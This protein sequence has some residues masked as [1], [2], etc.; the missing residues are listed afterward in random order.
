MFRKI[1]RPN[2]APPLPP[3]KDSYLPF[4]KIAVNHHSTMHFANMFCLLDSGCEASCVDEKLLKQL[5]AL[6]RM[7]ER[8][9]MGITTATGTTARVIGNIT[10][11]ITIGDKGT[12]K[13]TSFTHDF[14]VIES[15]ALNRILILGSNV[16]Q[17][18]AYVV[19][20]RPRSVDFRI[21][22]EYHVE[23]PKNFRAEVWYKDQMEKYELKV[24]F[25]THLDPGAGRWITMQAMNV[26]KDTD[27]LEITKVPTITDLTI[28]NIA[29]SPYKNLVTAY[30]ENTTNKPLIL[31][32]GETIANAKI[33]NKEII[34][35]YVMADADVKTVHRNISD[36]GEKPLSTKM[37][38]ITSIDNMPIDP[39]EMAETCLG[40]HFDMDN[41][42]PAI[43]PLRERFRV[44]DIPAEQ[45]KVLLDIAEKFPNVWA[46]SKLDIGTVP[47]LFVPLDVSDKVFCDKYRG[48]PK[49]TRHIIEAILQKYLDAG[50]LEIAP[51]SP[52]AMNLFLI[53]KPIPPHVL[54]ANPEAINSPE[55]YRTLLDAR[56]L[57]KNTQG[58]SLSLGQYE[59]LFLQLGSAK[60][61]IAIDIVS[62]YFNIRIKPEHRIYTSFYSTNPGEKLMF[63]RLGMGMTNSALEFVKLMTRIFKP[64]QQSV[65]MYMDDV[66]LFADSFEHICNTF[67]AALKILQENGLKLLPDKTELL[68][69]TIKFV[70]LQWDRNGTLSV[71]DAKIHA[72]SSWPVPL[73]TKKKIQSFCSAIQFFRRFIEDLSGKL[74][75]LTNMLKTGAKI[76]WNES[77]KMAFDQAI[78][79]LKQNVTLYIPPPNTSFI[80]H[81]DASKY[82]CAARLSYLDNDKIERLV[83]CASRTFSDTATRY[84]TYHQEL[85]ALIFAIRTYEGWCAFTPTTIYVDCISLTY[86]A[87]TKNSTASVMRISIYLSQFGNYKYVHVRSARNMADSLTRNEHQI[88]EV[89]ARNTIPPLTQIEAETLLQRL[90][91]PDGTEFSE[92]TVRLLLA[93]YPLPS[94]FSKKV[95]CRCKVVI[96]PTSKDIISTNPID[97]YFDN[98]EVNDNICADKK[99]LQNIDFKLIGVNNCNLIICDNDEKSA[100]RDTILALIANGQMSRTDLI[101]LQHADTYCDSICKQIIDNKTKTFY[102]DKGG[103]LRKRTECDNIENFSTDRIVLPEA[104]FKPLLY[105]SHSDSNYGAHIGSSHTLQTMRSKYFYPDMKHVIEEYCKSCLLCQIGKDDFQRRSIS[106]G[107]LRANRPRQIVAIDLSFSF[108]KTPKGHLGIAVMVDL[109]SNF[110]VAAPIR[111]KHSKELLEMFKFMYIIPFGIPESIRS[112]SE[113]GMMGGEFHDYCKQHEI[114]QYP[115]SSGSPWVNS[116]VEKKIHHLKDQ[117]RTIQAELKN[118]A[119]WVSLIPRI[120]GVNNNTVKTGK[121]TPY[122]IMFGSENTRRNEILS[123]IHTCCDIDSYFLTIKKVNAHIQELTNLHLGKH[124]LEGTEKYNENKIER[125]FKVDDLVWL[126]NIKI[127]TL[128]GNA[129]N[130]KFLGPYKII[131]I[132]DKVTALIT[133]INTGST[134]RRHF[135]FL[136]PLKIQNDTILLPIK[137][138][139]SLVSQDKQQIR[140]SERLKIKRQR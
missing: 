129:L 110:C 61:I 62:A 29:T 69:K 76:E 92:K 52:Y 50:I 90:I 96:P 87:L 27:I 44:K 126:K 99:L 10:L 67:K 35:E 53:K 70:G 7:Q 128:T 6:H 64:I 75:P 37:I 131:E 23:G 133:H 78:G 101:K 34:S 85:L 136:K 106:P 16:F 47:D 80:I 59:D 38:S 56:S 42:N 135:N 74:K 89:K 124:F 73:D 120:L 119:D 94:I 95:K 98:N 100:T 57:N 58:H 71:P 125:E 24:H 12:R 18:N 102:V 1:I 48:F 65:T 11:I 28:Q 41:T 86:L 138:D 49:G 55:Y 60:F 25:S 97:I 32:C 140:Q 22:D 121:Y 111:S 14:I 113:S 15:G 116:Q 20:Q 66:V 33:I 109:F 105:R 51:P 54:Q 63:A 127:P 137:W 5:H 93:S 103:V 72:F 30:V 39:V 19:Q 82:A 45:A 26:Y 4:L 46:S 68:P 84:S 13:Q 21:H 130:V 8:T 83:A 108:P 139:E 123:S 43:L 117:M 17:N 107:N 9:D 112:D 36:L 81:S 132:I 104:L 115:C 79:A 118:K 31:N 77:A 2:E 88:A 3:Q 114:S 40:P 91:I 122:N 134:M